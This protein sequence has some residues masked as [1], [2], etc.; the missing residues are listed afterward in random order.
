LNEKKIPWWEDVRARLINLD[1]RETLLQK[2]V[3][4]LSERVDFLIKLRNEKEK[5]ARWEKTLTITAVLTIIHLIL[6][7]IEVMK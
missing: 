7:L 5:Q 2:E 1:T 6:T 4:K 3:A